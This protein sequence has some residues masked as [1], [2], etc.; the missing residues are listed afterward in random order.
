[1]NEHD[2]RRAFEGSYPDQKNKFRPLKIILIIAVLLVIGGLAWLAMNG[3]QTLR[4]I[5]QTLAPNMQKR[6]EDF[7]SQQQDALKQKAADE[8]QH[9]PQV[10]YINEKQKQFEDAT[11]SVKKLITP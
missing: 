6:A 1:M 5:A 2:P 4:G 10:Q 7:V 3:V 11:S 9:T 8:I